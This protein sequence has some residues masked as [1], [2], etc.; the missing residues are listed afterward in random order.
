MLNFFLKELDAENNYLKLPASSEERSRRVN[1]KLNT[2]QLFHTRKTISLIR[3][4]S[5]DCYLISSFMSSEDPLF[6]ERFDSWNPVSL[7]A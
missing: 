2:R 6:L 1:L 3:C 4:N 7:G 5:C